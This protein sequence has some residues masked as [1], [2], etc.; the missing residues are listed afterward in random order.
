MGFSLRDVGIK[1]DVANP[2]RQKSRQ[3][4]GL[5]LTQSQEGIGIKTD[6]IINDCRVIVVF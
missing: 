4:W 1:L 3:G 6:A 2:H 5:G